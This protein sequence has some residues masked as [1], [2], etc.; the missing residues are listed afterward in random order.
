MGA[1]LITAATWLSAR[2][3][4]AEEITMPIALQVDL[5]DRVV[6][7]ERNFISRADEPAL[8]VVVQMDDTPASERAAAQADAAIEQ[9]ATLGGRPASVIIHTFSSAQALQTAARSAAI[10]Y[11]MP[12]FSRQ[13]LLE[14]ASTFA[15]SSVLT[16]T[17]SSAAVE[18]GLALGFEL[19]SSKPRI[20]VNLPQARAQR[21]DFSAQLLR[22]AR[23]VQ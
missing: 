10:L 2:A 14:I 16:V 9:A 11:V 5:L 17:A 7:F 19:E 23:V 22:L 15:G 13:E 6:R 21:L 20:V 8:V 4:A 3:G 12:G 18:S 1:A